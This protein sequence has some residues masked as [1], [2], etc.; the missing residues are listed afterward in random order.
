MKLVR[1]QP[2]FCSTGGVEPGSNS[3]TVPP[4]EL[5]MKIPCRFHHI[6]MIGGIEVEN[7]YRRG[8]IVGFDDGGVIIIDRADGLIFPMSFSD[9]TVEKEWIDEN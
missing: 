3:S 5:I 9:I 4:L 1:L 8:F 2:P 7:E 6:A